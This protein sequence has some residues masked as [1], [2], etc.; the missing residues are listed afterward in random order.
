MKILDCFQL[1]GSFLPSW[2]R[3]RNLRAD[4]DMDPAA[5]INADPC[6]SGSK[7]LL[8]DPDPELDPDP[9]YLAKIQRHLGK[10]VQYFIIFHQCCG[11]GSGIRCFYD[12]LIRDTDPEWGKKSGSGSGMN[13]PDN[14]S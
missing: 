11:S 6:G 9:F 3:I 1:F 2:I 8:L 13:I 10:K 12:P 5:Q 4:P 7:T 14:F